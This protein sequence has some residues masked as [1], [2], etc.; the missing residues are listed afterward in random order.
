MRYK[1]LA[2]FIAFNVVT[3]LF[4]LTAFKSWLIAVIFLVVEVA[5]ILTIFVANRLVRSSNWFRS[6]HAD[7]DHEIYPDNTWYR[8]HDERNYDLINLGSNSAKYAFD[9]L[10]EPVRAMNWSSGTQTLHDDYKLVRNFHSILKEN[11][12][13][14]ITIMPFTSIN[15]KTGLADAF[16]FWKVL[17]STQTAPEYRKKCRLLERLPIFFGIPAIKSAAKVVLGKDKQPIDLSFA[18][19][20]PM[21]EED[22]KKHAS[23]MINS[24]KAEFSIDNLAQPLTAQNQKGREVRIDVMRKMLDFLKERGYRTAF[25]IPPVSSYLKKYFT[26]PFREIYI[27][28]YLRQIDRDI[29]IFDYL[30]SDEFEDKDLYFNSYYF[31]KRGAKIFTHRVISDLKKSNLL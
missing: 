4:C 11:G 9:Y 25:V 22:L 1:L 31:N 6:L 30:K 18:D 29:T 12:T 20:N 14:V 19:K 5:A 13:V 23:D 27:Y 15:K 21:P 24:W 17:D 16:R 7:P 3:L 2:A 8:K 10:D 28:S 26:E